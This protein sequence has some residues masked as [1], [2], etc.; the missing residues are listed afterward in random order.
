M[1]AHDPANKVMRK[2]AILGGKGGGTLAAQVVLN[3]ARATGSLALAGY[4]NDRLPKGAPLH[5]G[6]V[7]SGFDDWHD[8]D[9]DVHF[10]APLHKAGHIET[11]AARIAGLA[12]PD[13]RWAT[14]VDPSASVADGVRVGLGTV[15]AP[16]VAL[17]PDAVVGN[18]CFLRA[19][20]VVSHDV[21]IG[22]YVFVGSRA[23]ISGYCRVETGAHIAPGAVVRDG[24]AIGAYALVGTGAVVTKD[25][26]AYTLV[27]GNPARTRPDSD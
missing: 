13:A 6:A 11:N 22:D 1:Q 10:V 15:I 21:A 16:L 14:L 17:C 3:V 7:L 5:G 20:S 12:I 23:V 24:V 27:T 19:G 26:P 2:V 18:H 25:V 9:P 4:L 8:L